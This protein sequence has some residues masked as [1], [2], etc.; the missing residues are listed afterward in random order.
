MPVEKDTRLKTIVNQITAKIRIYNEQ[1]PKYNSDYNRF[2]ISRSNG[3]KNENGINNWL[4]TE[5]ASRSVYKLMDDFGMNS[6]ASELVGFEIFNLNLKDATA[7][8][9][10]ESLEN[11]DISCNSLS[12][13]FGCST[14]RDELKE[15][16]NY[17]S[18]PGRFSESGGF[19]IGTK[20]AH[21]LLPHICPMIDGRHIGISLNNI[22]E[23]DYYPPGNSWVN[24]L[25]YSPQKKTNP[26]PKGE[27]RYSWKDTQFLCAIGF[28]VQVYKEWQKEHDNPGIDTFL[29]LDSNNYVSGIPRI[30]DKALW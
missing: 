27:G 9:D 21:C 20:V 16:F 12:T 25:G 15:L 1:N 3:I 26:S 6:R 11:F 17:C 10:L 2:F 19:V 5:E 7:N 14:A 29:D 22:H 4:K 28:Y 24:Y 13:A 8:I 18:S 23:N 30:I